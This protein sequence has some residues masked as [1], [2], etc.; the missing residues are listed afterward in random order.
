MELSEIMPSIE[1]F[2]SLV[3]EINFDK[4]ELDFQKK[5]AK[6][7]GFASWE[8]YLQRLYK[9]KF[10]RIDRMN[11]AN[12]LAQNIQQDI[13]LSGS[14]PLLMNK[15]RNIEF[16]KE[17][18]PIFEKVRSFPKEMQERIGDFEIKLYKYADHLILEKHKDQPL[19][20]D[21]TKGFVK[22]FEIQ[23]LHL[24]S[25]AEAN[26][27]IDAFFLPNLNAAINKHKTFNFYFP[28]KRYLLRKLHVELVEAKFIEANDDFEKTFETQIKP[29]K[30]QS[31]LWLGDITK[32]F[33]LLY[34]LNDKKEYHANGIRLDKIADKLFTFKV[35]CSKNSIATNF[36]KSVKR[37]KRNIYVKKKM[38]DIEVVLEKLGIS[39]KKVVK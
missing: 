19:V 15:H 29:L 30:V 28:K 14:I 2:F 34:R 18:K 11:F 3:N 20:M 1:E 7:A 33:Y 8:D 9:M 12:E 26:S 25:K 22:D 5:M 17:L 21:V 36:A 24:N 13:A 4:A 16:E 32:L 6:K 35:A 23:D 27:N 10:F 38:T 37:F 39:T 31:T